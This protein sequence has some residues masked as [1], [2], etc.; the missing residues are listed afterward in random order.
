MVEI[1]RQFDW[2]PRTFDAR[3]GRATPSEIAETLVGTFDAFGTSRIGQMQTD[4]LLGGVGNLELAHDQVPLQRWRYYIS[5]EYS[6][7]D[8]VNR[9]LAPARLV[10]GPAGVTITR[11]RDEISVPADQRLAVR[12][13]SVGPGDFMAIETR[14]IGGGA[15]LS[16]RPVWIDIPL[17]ESFSGIL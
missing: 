3:A 1:R 12:T 14:A 10:R 17:G 6:H 7:D 13:I 16:M 4:V 8:V 9:L 5:V 11:F 2:I 15:Q